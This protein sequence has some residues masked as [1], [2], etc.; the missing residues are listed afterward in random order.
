MT[1]TG[2]RPVLREVVEQPG[3]V[4]VA[5]EVGGRTFVGVGDVA[6][7]G[8]EP[9]VAAA[10]RAALDALEQAT[11]GAVALRLDW[12]MIVE[13]EGVLPPVV[14]VLVTATIAGVPLRVTGSVLLR[15]QPTWAGARAALQALNRRLEI[16]AL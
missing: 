4:R 10:A 1:G 7:D 3:T 9:V 5:L 16:M 14:V 2:D 11:P 13:P 15:D 8:T 12:S 6:G